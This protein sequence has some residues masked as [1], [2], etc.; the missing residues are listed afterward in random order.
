MTD[1]FVRR[2]IS[3]LLM[4]CALFALSCT[5][6]RNDPKPEPHTP[7]RKTATASASAHTSATASGSTSTSSKPVVVDEAALAGLSLGKLNDREKALLVKAMDKLSSPCSDTPVPL[8][9]CVK[10][11]RACKLCKP[12]GEF[13]GR[14]VRTGATESDLETVYKARF[15]ASVVK[16]VEVGKAPFKGAEDA[17]V[18]IVEFADFQCPGCR[19]ARPFMELILERFPGQVRLAYKYYQITG[20]DRALE[21]AYAAQAAHLQGK[22]WEMHKQLFDNKDALARSDFRKY[23]REIG[24][25][26]DKF[27]SDFD[28]EDTKK[29]VA[30]D[31]TQANELGL[32]HT[33]L[34]YVNGREMTL[35]P[36][37]EE[38][39]LW[40]Q[41][42][43]EQAGVVPAEP[44]EKYKEMAKTLRQAPPPSDGATPQT[45]A[46]A[47]PEG[48]ASTAPSGSAPSSASA[49]PSAAQPSASAPASAGAKPSASASAKPKAAPPPPAPAP[50]PAAPPPPAP[51]PAPAPQ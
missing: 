13:L 8:S 12:A 4:G 21:A 28:S 14:M 42:E 20:H 9:Q 30:A 31:I 51:A 44:T 18:T 3:S 50:K 25:D 37:T 33:P 23:A 39:E 29:A 7:G 2:P 16:T 41:L 11:K 49:A 6:P 27:N 24:L 34:I 22:F 15:D 17:P 26:L 10:E 36:F 5:D 40:V 47:S 35:N 38:F 46:S 1:N 45:S 48:S 19:E 32:E 43:L